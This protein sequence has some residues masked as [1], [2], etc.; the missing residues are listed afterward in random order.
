ML[1][2]LAFFK[3]LFRNRKGQTALE[4]A[5]ILGVISFGIYFVFAEKLKPVMT[6]GIEKLSGK[7]SKEFGL[8]SESR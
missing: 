7:V 1:K 5:L 4:Y 8:E 3:R 2:I 6:Q